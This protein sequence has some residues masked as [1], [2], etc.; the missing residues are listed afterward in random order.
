MGLMVIS[1]IGKEENLLSRCNFGGG[2]LMVWGAFGSR[3]KSRIVFVKGHHSRLHTL[4]SEDYTELLKESLLPCF[5]KINSKNP[6]FQ[7]DGA[8][9]HSSNHTKNWLQNKKIH[10]LQWAPNSPDLNPIENSSLVHLV[11]ANGKQFNKV[12]ELKE[13]IKECWDQIT[14]D[15]LKILFIQCQ[16][17][18]LR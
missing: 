9:I 6:I 13:K 12:I 11:Y 2:S 4:D 10:I 17:E 14:L 18:L 3:G 15:E 5:E 8:S 16:I 1:I 7:Q